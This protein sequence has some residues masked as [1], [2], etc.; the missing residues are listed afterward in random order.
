MPTQLKFELVDHVGGDVQ[1]LQFLVHSVEMALIECEL[2]SI[3]IVHV[4]D[5]ILRGAFPFVLLLGA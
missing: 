3:V 1:L 5:S 4:V 2:H